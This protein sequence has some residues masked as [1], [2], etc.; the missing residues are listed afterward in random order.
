[1]YQHVQNA[2]VMQVSLKHSR[3]GMT[4]P[5]DSIAILQT[6]LKLTAANT[7]IEVGVYTGKSS[8]NPLS[9]LL[10]PSYHNHSVPDE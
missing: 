4:S 10:H 8:F 2:E 1:M 6:L 9:L 7:A 3:G 5:P